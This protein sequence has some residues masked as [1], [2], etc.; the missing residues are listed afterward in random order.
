MDRRQFPA[1]N[2]TEHIFSYLVGPGSNGHMSYFVRYMVSHTHTCIYQY[3]IIAPIR[4]F[5]LWYLTGR[6]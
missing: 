6:Q 3:S 2:S 4:V 5:V 1:Q